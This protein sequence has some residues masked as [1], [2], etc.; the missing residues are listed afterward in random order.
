M[1]RLAIANQ[2]DGRNVGEVSPLLSAFP[3]S[4]CRNVHRFTVHSLFSEGVIS[5]IYLFSANNGKNS[6][7]S[8]GHS[9]FSEG[10][11]TAAAPANPSTG[12]TA[13]ESGQCTCHRP[14]VNVPVPD[15]LVNV[16][17]PLTTGLCT[18]LLDPS[19]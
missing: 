1:Y 6:T 3:V 17:V 14:L 11:Y 9:F 19:P 12:V 4:S 15:P 2:R 13:L 5:L 18:C 8:T 10:V 7:V 16:P